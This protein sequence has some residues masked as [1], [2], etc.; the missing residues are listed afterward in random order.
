MTPKQLGFLLEN[1]GRN[2]LLAGFVI[3]LVL[4]LPSSLPAQ[5]SS[6]N[7]SGTVVDSSGA[8]IPGAKVTVVASATEAR[9][10]AVADST[11]FYVLPDLPIGSYALRVE[12][13]GFQTYVQEGIVLEVNRPLTVNPTLQV[14][15]M[16][17]SVTVSGQASQVDTR[18]GTVNYEITATMARD[19][20]LNGRNVLQLMNMA[21]D[22][23][24]FP[25]ST[26]HP[27][28]GPFVQSA[29]RPE[30]GMLI[31]SAA[32]GRGNSSIFYLDGGVNEDPDTTV[33]NIFPNPDA[34]QQFSVDTS[35]YAAK[36]GSRGGGV[37][38]AVTKSG[39]NAFH[40][41]AFEYLRY[42]SLNARNFFSPTQDGL[43]R[44]QFGFTFGGPIQKDKTFLF[45]A[46][47]GTDLRLLPTGNISPAPTAAELSGDF[48]GVAGQLINPSTGAAF[49]GNQV[50]P[51]LFNPIAMKILTGYVPVGDAATG[52]TTYSSRT[53]SN[54][55]QY[56]SRLDRT[57]GNTVHVYASYLYDGLSEPSTAV[58]A[59]LLA[60][61]PTQYWRSQFAAVNTTWNVTPTLI[62]AFVASVSR[63]TNLYTGSAGLPTWTGLGANVPNL[64][65]CGP[66]TS[67]QL[68]I[69]GYFSFLQDGCYTIPDTAED[70]ASNWT[71]IKGKHT[72]EFGAELLFTKDNKKQD[73]MGDGRYNFSGDLSGDNLLDFMLG[74]PSEFIQQESFYFIDEMTLPMGYVSDTWKAT[75]KLSVS[76]GVRWNPYVP[77]ADVSYHQAGLFDPAAFRAGVHSTLYPNLPPG[78]LVQGDP[79]VPPR[80]EASYYGLFDPRLGFAYALSQS[81]KSVIRGGYGMFQQ[82]QLG[83]IFNPTYTPFSTTADLLYPVGGIANPYEGQVD[84]FPVPQPAPHNITPV[85]P[86]GGVNPYTRHMGAQT[87]QQWNLTTEQQLPF[88]TMLRVSYEGA[89][90]WHMDSTIEGNPAIYNPAETRAQNLSDTNLRRPMGQYYSSMPLIENIATQNY[91]ALVISA[92][93]RVSHGLSFLTGYRWAKCM[94]EIEVGWREFTSLNPADDYGRCGYDVTNQYRFSYNWAL[95][96]LGSLGFVGK[97]IIG[98]WTSNGILTLA[99]GPPYTVWSGVDNSLSGIGL[100]RADVVG[101]P[102]LGSG[103]SRGQEA[104]E[105]FNTAA[106]TTNALGTFGDSGKNFLSGPGLANF[107]FSMIKSIPIAKG[108]RAETQRLEFRAE[109]FN[110]FNHPNLMLAPNI[111]SNA[112]G[113]FGT[114]GSPGFGKITLAADPRIIQFALKF[115][116]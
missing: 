85:L 80:V 25:S 115:V 22:V 86:E 78:L 5:R 98:G 69:G 91:N 59:N 96:T 44:N 106:F 42:Y 40:G 73:F 46:F 55:H 97:N 92:E 27:Q 51:T 68:S 9:S 38:N 6:A 7:I 54:D 14:G 107:D 100:D 81:G 72:I 32:G 35:S 13:D 34:I 10:S 102:N 83:Q 15:R 116:F 33:P 63:R 113:S 103:R 89:N 108:P 101:N 52:L 61:Q 99:S 57:F 36:F 82:Q 48:S 65:N 90:A 56:V 110:L 105:W 31:S 26:T 19:L 30:D 79:D 66:K 41:D 76:L 53:V 37:I 75:R 47:Q 112:G 3:T 29:S 23:T 45:V 12:K 43:K 39:T 87:G 114:V 21:P 50:S 77:L 1:R 74:Y 20:P 49:T 95:P 93:K 11:G 2:I 24:A 8:A 84:P 4:A 94:D 104:A 60:A 17:Q 64:V 109:F 70:Y 18:S 28:G 67:L 71:W 88:V 111:S 58:G 62:A 16:A